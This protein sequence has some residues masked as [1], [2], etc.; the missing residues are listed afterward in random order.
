MDDKLCT[1]FADYYGLDF[2]YV[3]FSFYIFLFK[4]VESKISDEKT[5]FLF[6]FIII[7][8]K[9]WTAYIDSFPI[10]ELLDNGVFTGYVKQVNFIFHI[11]V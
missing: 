5:P 1:N 9:D 10:E 2:G 6:F 7:K 11:M 3:N 4:I 8:L